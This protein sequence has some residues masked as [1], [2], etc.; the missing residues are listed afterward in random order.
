MPSLQ[1]SGVKLELQS[2][3]WLEVLC[4]QRLFIHV[5]IWK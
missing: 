3:Q 1:H 2:E 4:I 5:L